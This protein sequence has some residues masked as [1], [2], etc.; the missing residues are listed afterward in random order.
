MPADVY[1]DLATEVVAK[2][3]PVMLILIVIDGEKGNGLSVFAA[4]PLVP[5]V[6]YV[7]RET[8]EFVEANRVVLKDAFPTHHHAGGL[9]S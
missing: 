7:L 3:K 4:E 6:A 2:V 8:A 9:E 5:K 1:D